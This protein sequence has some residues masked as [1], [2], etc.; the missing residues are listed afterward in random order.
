MTRIARL[1]T[2]R[3]EESF[4]ELFAHEEWVRKLARRL[5]GASADDAAQETW[6][7]ALRNP[8]EFRSARAATS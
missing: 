6:I 5:C 8:R 2:P 3:S 4:D 7:E 1:G